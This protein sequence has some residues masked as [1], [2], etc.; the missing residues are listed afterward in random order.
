MSYVHARNFGCVSNLPIYNNDPL[1]YCMESQTSP[2]FNH[3]SSWMSIGQNSQP[4]QIYLAS[5]CAQKWDGICEQLSNISTSV[6]T[7]VQTTSQSN[8]MYLTPGDI[9]L[10][11][12]AQKKY[13]AKMLGTD[14]NIKTSPFDPV[15]LGGSPYITYYVGNCYPVYVVDPANIDNDPVM[16]KLLS[17]PW[18]AVDFF[19]KLKNSMLQ[20]GLFTSLKG[21]RLGQFYG[22]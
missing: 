2:A 18:I 12:T 14:C 15:A 17:K 13:L 6:S 22:L 8:G 3:S 20:I 21:T 5:R 16:N 10:V 4:C 9:L 1:T 11:N 19:I 7:P